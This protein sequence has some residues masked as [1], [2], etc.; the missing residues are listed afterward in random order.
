M[1]MK[2][3]KKKNHKQF[4]KYY[5]ITENPMME[6]VHLLVIKY[7]NNIVRSDRLTA[8]QLKTILL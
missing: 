1:M 8:C 4:Y 2:P 3:L 6:F 7:K 5:T